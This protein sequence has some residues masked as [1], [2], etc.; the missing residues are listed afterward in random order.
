[1]IEIRYSSN[2]ISV[3]CPAKKP[4]TTVKEE[5]PDLVLTDIMMPE[6]DGIELIERIKGDSELASLPIVAMSA[7]G[8]EVL[9]DAALVGAAK[10]LEKSIDPFSLFD[11]VQGVL[12]SK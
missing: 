8:N 1:V 5:K 7:C 10:I 4:G 2:G 11:E 9:Q 6:M 12:P 3:T